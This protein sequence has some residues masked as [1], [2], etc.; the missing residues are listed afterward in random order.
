MSEYHP[1][2]HIEE[3]EV[4][5]KEQIDT[6]TEQFDV[7]FARSQAR[8]YSSTT[9]SNIPTSN[10]TPNHPYAKSQPQL[11]SCR[12][13]PSR[14]PSSDNR[15]HQTFLLQSTT[16]SSSTGVTTV[17]GSGGSGEPLARSC[18]YKRPQSIKK[19]RRKEKEQKRQGEAKEYSSSSSRKSTQTTQNNNISRTGISVDSLSRRKSSRISIND[20]MANDD[21]QWSSPR[22]QRSTRLGSLPLDQLQI[23]TDVPLDEEIYR[24]RQFNTTSK[25]FVNR[26]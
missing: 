7:L 18:S 4:P 13:S 6:N 11:I 5:I 19:Y 20:L 1:T 16:R 12:T 23:P 14:S 15:Q 24:V 25:G 17:P 21:E 2:E 8:S 3:S 10:E 26:G 9:P 22:T